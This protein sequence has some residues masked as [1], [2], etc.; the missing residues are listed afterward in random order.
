MKNSETARKSVVS[1]INICY[2]IFML[3]RKSYL[4]ALPLVFSIS[5]APIANAMDFEISEE[6]IDNIKANCN[7]IKQTLKRVQNSD[8]N[9]RVSLGQT[10]QLI[11]ADYITPL[12]LRLVKN[13]ISSPE[14]SSV[15]SRF[16]SAREDFNRKY[17]TYSQNLENLMNA[18]CKSDPI[19]FYDKLIQTRESRQTVAESVGIINSIIDDQER[20]VTL[21]RDS[22][23]PELKLEEFHE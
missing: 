7:D 11:M 21:L 23:R 18:D 9:T 17:I 2:N 19:G 14:L 13:N 1:S 6:K 12:N 15:Q 4:L 10:Y 20:N 3:W 16:A 5:L 22:L 8:R